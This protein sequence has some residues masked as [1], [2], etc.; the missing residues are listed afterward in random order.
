MPASVVEEVRS[1]DGDDIRV[2][3]YEDVKAY[4]CVLQTTQGR[5]RCRYVILLD[6][7]LFLC[8]DWSFDAWKRSGFTSMLRRCIVWRY[9]SLL[10]ELI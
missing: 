8:T 7:A 3:F 1:D 6:M 5:D 2:V 10:C 4:L 9:I